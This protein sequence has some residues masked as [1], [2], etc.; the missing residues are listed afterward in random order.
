MASIPVK[1]TPAQQS[2]ETVEERFRRLSAAWN[3][4]VAYHSSTT[5]RN[6]HPAYRE[7]IALGPEVVPLCCAIWKKT[8]PT[9]FVPCVKS[10][11]PIRFPNRPRA[12]SP[13]WWKPGCAG[14]RTTIIDGNPAGKDFSTA[15]ASDPPI[16]ETMAT[17]YLEE[18]D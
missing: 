17:R 4:A 10:P 7:I 13:K 12:I 15:G 8:R 14:Q 5:I 6:R 18:K 11:G 2:V 3:E 9:G 16:D 1:Q